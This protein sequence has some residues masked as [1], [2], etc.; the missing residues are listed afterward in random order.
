MWWHQHSLQTKNA[1]AGQVCVYTVYNTSSHLKS[2]PSH[3]VWFRGLR[4][5]LI[6]ESS[7]YPAQPVTTPDARAPQASSGNATLE[8][9]AHKKDRAPKQSYCQ[10]I[11]RQFSFLKGNFLGAGYLKLLG[12]AG[13]KRFQRDPTKKYTNHHYTHPDCI[14][15]AMQSFHQRAACPKENSDIDYSIIYSI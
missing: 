13:D 4:D 12:C 14:Q 7:T 2:V 6:R 8:F 3:L 15:Y 10:M 9:S 11:G 1:P 5:V